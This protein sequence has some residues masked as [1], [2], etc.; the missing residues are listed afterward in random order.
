[1]EGD[2]DWGSDFSD[3]SSDY[4]DGE[5][6]ENHVAEKSS[7]GNQLQIQCGQC[8]QM[9]DTREL[10]KDHLEVHYAEIVKKILNAQLDVNSY[11]DRAKEGHG[12]AME[13]TELSLFRDPLTLTLAPPPTPAS[14]PPP[15][16]SAFLQ[17]PYPGPAPSRPPSPPPSP[18]L[19]LETG[20]KLHAEVSGKKGLKEQ[21]PG[22]N[23]SRRRAKEGPYMEPTELILLPDPLR[24]TLSP[25]PSPPPPPPPSPDLTLEIG[26]TFR[27]FEKHHLINENKIKAN[28]TEMDPSCSDDKS[29]LALKL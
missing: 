20:I 3:W 28:E 15:S 29:D 16:P 2:Y 12:P 18:D 9:V 23:S 5:H 8:Q 13:P 11:K 6:K 22:V 21:H 17:P 26:L 4:E 27:G 14:S 24:L 7:P 19:T 10:L 1:M 25:P